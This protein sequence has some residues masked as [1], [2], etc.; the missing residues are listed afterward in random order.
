MPPVK[1]LV[2]SGPREKELSGE[3][4]R[5]KEMSGKSYRYLCR[6]AG[7]QYRTFMRHKKNVRSMS[8]DELWRFT[9]IC[10][11]EASRR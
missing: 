7:I 10:E 2:R 5:L 11:K 6:K 3:I 4:G 9:D 8:H 1:P